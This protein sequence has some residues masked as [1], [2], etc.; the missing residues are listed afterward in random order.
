MKYMKKWQNNS[1]SGV[2]GHFESYKNFGF[3]INL[4][5]VSLNI[6]NYKSLGFT[7]LKSQNSGIFNLI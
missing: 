7:M 6:E 1:P 4:Q 3:T 5:L 2:I